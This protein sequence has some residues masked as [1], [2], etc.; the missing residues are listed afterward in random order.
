MCFNRKVIAGLVVAALGTYLVAPNLLASA[1]PLLLVAACPLSMLLMGKAMMGGQGTVPA[2]LDSRLDQPIPSPTE[3]GL[4][5]DE[6]VA[7]LQAQLQSLGQ[8]QAELTLQLARIEPSPTTEPAG[9]ALAKR[10]AAASAATTG[11]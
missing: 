1:L 4:D 9:A 2:T 3:A 11:S 5:R 8:Q 10:G 7:Q 6:R